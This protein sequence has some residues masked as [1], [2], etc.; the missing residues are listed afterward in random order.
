MGCPMVSA[1]DEVFASLL[2][3]FATASDI[4]LCRQTGLFPR[5]WRESPASVSHGR[6]IDNF[7]S[8]GV[9][10]AS[11]GRASLLRLAA[12]SQWV[13]C[14]VRWDCYLPSSAQVSVGA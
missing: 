7:L 9:P 13:S 12:P 3:G 2:T 14:S 4:G 11:S 1:G 8:I 6:D 5:L 10:Q